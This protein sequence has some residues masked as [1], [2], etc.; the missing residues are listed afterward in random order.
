M[1]PAVGVV[2]TASVMAWVRRYEDAWRAGDLAAVEGLFTEEAHYRPSPYDDS[3][4]GH[5]AIK[6]FWR[7]DEGATFEVQAEPVAVQDRTAVVR[8]VVRY[9]EPRTQEYTDL[10]VVRF[11]TDGRAEDFEEWAYWP[12]RPYSAGAEAAEHDD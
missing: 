9:L 7:D 5:D 1:S 3:E 12:G 6:A 8:V 11:A 10:W 4:V 2:D